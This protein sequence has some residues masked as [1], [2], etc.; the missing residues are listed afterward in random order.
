MPTTTTL[1]LFALTT[2][3]L[4]AAPGPGIIYIVGRSVDQGRR[5]GFVSMLAIESAEVVYVLAV[6][7]GLAA[8]LAA[9]TRALQTLRFVGAAY[10]LVL[11]VRRWRQAG[12]VAQQ[13]TQ[14][15]R[16]IFAHG[17]FVQLVNPKV[18]VFFVA[19][20]PQFLDPRSA[21]LPQV[22]LLGCVYVSI[23]CASDA[24]YVLASARLARRLAR[25]LRARRMLARCSALTY[26]ALGVFA[27]LAGDRTQ[28]AHAARR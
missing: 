2:L 5:A 9:S 14:S 13:R 27:A 8:V 12:A 3:L 18:A 22:L 16:R 1:L 7:I 4:V 15:G 20:F 10:L 26:I 28:P 11:G 24:A 17:F 23:A 6:A 21:I 19:Y 25:S